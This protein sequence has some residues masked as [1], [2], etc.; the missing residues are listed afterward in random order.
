MKIK[1]LIAEDEQIERLALRFIVGN[2]LPQLDIVAEASNGVELIELARVHRPDIMIIDIR[3]PAIDGLSAIS[4]I[5][6][7]LPEIEFL[8]V[9]AHADFE[10][11]QQAIQLGASNYLVKPIKTEVL[12]SELNKI[13][14]KISGFH[15]KQKTNQKL[16]H[17]FEMIKPQVDYN[18]LLAVASS[19]ITDRISEQFYSIL[20]LE[21]DHYFCILVTN[22]S[23]KSITYDLQE[24]LLTGLK[25]HLHKVSKEFIVGFVGG[26]LLLIMP[27]SNQFVCSDSK[28]YVQEIS[29]ITKS[30][31]DNCG[32]AAEIQTS[33]IVSSLE[34]ISVEYKCMLEFSYSRNRFAEQLP[35]EL[36]SLELSMCEHV[37]AGNSLSSIDELN[38]ILSYINKKSNGVEK[39]S[40]GLLRDVSILLK[41]YIFSDKEGF[42]AFRDSFDQLEELFITHKSKQ[43]I[44]DGI[45]AIVSSCAFFYEKKLYK[46]IS[47]KVDDIIEY[48][49]KNYKKDFS[50]ETLA[51]DNC[52][53]ASYL[54]K[55][56]KQRLCKNYIDFIT[57]LRVEEAKRLL[58]VTSKSIK[59]ITFEIGY[60]SQTYFCKVFKKSVGVSAS[61]YKEKFNF[62][63][64]LD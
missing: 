56:L 24:R 26:G 23:S 58:S 32:I 48:I 33:N 47:S 20:D 22:R 64:K 57:D 15:A 49:K 40:L 31:L 16:H 62:Q 35:Q 42:H 21:Y 51:F 54:S 7:F 30:Y 27:F 4:Q 11:A 43:D 29:D 60:N 38:K 36:Y 52:L 8:V 28:N 12:I 45:F 61:E 53:S 2:N 9:T 17:N 55:A 1:I 13:S 39:E 34:E 44:I 18:I 63:N 59:E 3:M 10:Y 14:E 5:R 46:N 19:N 25:D 50:L 37:V 6:T 41:S